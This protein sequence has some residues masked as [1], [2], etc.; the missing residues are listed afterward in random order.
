M[1]EGHVA[2][3]GRGGSSPLSGTTKRPSDAGNSRR[4]GVFCLARLSG[5]AR[6]RRKLRGIEKDLGPFGNAVAKGRRSE[7]VLHHTIHPFRAEVAVHLRDLRTQMSK[8]LENT[9]PGT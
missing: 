9:R 8:N 3:L 2:V 5:F 6:H 7:R 4:R 1:V